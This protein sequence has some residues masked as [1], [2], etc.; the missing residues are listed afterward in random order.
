MTAGQSGGSNY[1][2]NNLQDP[3]RCN[4]KTANENIKAM[5]QMLTTKEK[6]K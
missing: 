3:K 2:I 6:V 1:K 5:L 4:G